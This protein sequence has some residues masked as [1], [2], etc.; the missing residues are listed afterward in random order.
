MFSP[1]NSPGILAW[2]EILCVDL[3]MNQEEEEEEER[4]AGEAPHQRD[5]NRKSTIGGA[6]SNTGK[7]MEISK[8]SSFSTIGSSG[9][10]LAKT[11]GGLRN[12]RLTI[13]MVLGHLT[14]W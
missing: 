11:S 10:I 4:V 12:L 14:N 13:E 8:M 6:A 2:K 5:P 1:G 3:G 9:G 7:E